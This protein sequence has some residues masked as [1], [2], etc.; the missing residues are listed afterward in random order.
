MWGW[1]GEVVITVLSIGTRS[2][3]ELLFPVVPSALQHGC[4]Q[5]QAPL[6]FLLIYIHVLAFFRQLR[7]AHSRPSFL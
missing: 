1:E 7:E 2:A 6:L 4:H 3:D 5:S